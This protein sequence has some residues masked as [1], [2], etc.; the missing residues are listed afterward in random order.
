MRLAE[1]SG[2]LGGAVALYRRLVRTYPDLMPGERS[3]AHLE[4][5]FTARGERGL[6]AH[7]AWTHAIYP[8]LAHTPL[9]DNLVFFAARAAHA[10]YLASGSRAA[11]DLAEALYRRLDR[12]HPTGGLWNDAWWERSLLYAAQG[13]HDDEIAAIR[14]LQRTYERL[15]LFG[16]DDHPYFAQ[17]Q[18]RIARLELLALG[19]PR[20]AAQSY[21]TYADRFPLSRHRDDAL[22]WAGCAAL[23]AGDP[24][25]AS[26]HF[27]ALERDH[28]ESKYL[29]RL[30][31]ARRDPRGGPCVPP[32][33]VAVPAPPEEAP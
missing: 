21:A 14:R 32:E 33:V 18:L 22:F 6:E 8:D 4:R 12:D 27:A 29:R 31:D 28:P 3:L 24:A 1:A 25:A 30:D 10:R 23:A 5:L 17:G 16:H 26:A 19:R 15:S 2:D 11:A 20:D 13:R 9:G 7:L